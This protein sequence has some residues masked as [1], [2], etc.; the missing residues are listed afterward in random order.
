MN[1]RFWKQL[2]PVEQLRIVTWNVGGGNHALGPSDRRRLNG[3]ANRIMAFRPNVVLL[4]EIERVGSPRDR[5][6]YHARIQARLRRRGLPLRG[7]FQ[8][9]QNPGHIAHKLGRSFLTDL[10]FSE[11]SAQ[12]LGPENAQVQD[13]VV[14]MPSGIKV[15]IFHV[16]QHV[17]DA[18]D[19]VT[20][21]QSKSPLPY[22][23]AGDF[24]MDRPSSAYDQLVA[25]L[26]VTNACYSQATVNH[27]ARP[28]LGIPKAIDFILCGL[29]EEWRSL[30]GYV[31]ASSE[32]PPLSDHFPV[33]DAFI[34]KAALP[35]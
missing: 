35:G 22:L 12:D 21:I 8:I 28:D 18:P 2:G 34:L 27:V 1:F 25:D 20:H 7:R 6:D 24:N 4:Q 23:V 33:F 13:F 3:I 5:V 32:L 17:Q 26:G 14:E 29:G 15:R 19:L 31:H 9:G 30:G 16:H 11:V 10:P